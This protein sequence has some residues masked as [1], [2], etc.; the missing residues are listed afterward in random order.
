MEP[1]NLNECLERAISIAWNELKY[2]VTLEKDLGDLPTV[3]CYP[4]QLGQVFLNF[5]VNAAHAIEQQGVI[6][7]TTRAEDN[8][9]T[10]AVSDSG[11][12]IAEE[13]M[14]RIFEPFFT[15]KEVGTGTGLGLAISYE[16]VQRH[17]GTIDVASEVGK[18]TTF[19]VHL[20]IGKIG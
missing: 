14:D 8:Y 17:N 15:T 2:K 20:P 3:N 11:C 7:V 9:V 5:L 6:R 16:I 12:G 18:G 19:T 10:I 13:N 1:A 4:Q